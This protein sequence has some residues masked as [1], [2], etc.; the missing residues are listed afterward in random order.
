M[1]TDK[2]EKYISID[3][4]SSNEFPLKKKRFEDH[5]KKRRKGDLVGVVRAAYQ[6]A[7]KAVAFE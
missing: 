3:I 1:V 5:Y 7:D 2:I 4:F 6:R